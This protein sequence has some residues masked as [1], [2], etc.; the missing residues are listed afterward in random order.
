M[1]TPRLPS[2]IIMKC[3]VSIKYDVMKVFTKGKMF[4]IYY[5]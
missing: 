5:V 3:C 1:F 2:K 4:T